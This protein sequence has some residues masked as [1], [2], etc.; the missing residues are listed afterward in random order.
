[1]DELKVFL[2]QPYLRQNGEKVARNVMELKASTVLVSLCGRALA[3]LLVRTDLF[4]GR[5]IRRRSVAAVN[6]R[7]EVGM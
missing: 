7:K 6:T 3:A 4:N 2:H 1:M 5:S